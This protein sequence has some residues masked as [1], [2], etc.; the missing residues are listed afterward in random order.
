MTTPISKAGPDIQ[1]IL[2]ATRF[3]VP[4]PPASYPRSAFEL[5]TRPTET[6]SEVCVD[7]I[8]EGVSRQMSFSE[9]A[10]MTGLRRESCIQLG[11]AAL[12]WTSLS[13][14]F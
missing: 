2:R 9:T 8:Q 7:Q 14:S 12:G 6:I 13:P 10:A 4:R 5:G 11:I 1:S 3:P